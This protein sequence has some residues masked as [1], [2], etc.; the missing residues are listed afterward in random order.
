MKFITSATISKEGYACKFK[1]ISQ[2][3]KYKFLVLFNE[4][5]IGKGKSKSLSSGKQIANNIIKYHYNKTVLSDKFYKII[6]PEI[7]ELEG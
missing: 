2:E 3:A 6:E 4:K 7:H 1:W 5:T